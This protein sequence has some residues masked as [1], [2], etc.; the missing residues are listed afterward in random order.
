MKH[1]A[2]IF[3]FCGV[4]FAGTCAAE[5]NDGL[6]GSSIGSS[7]KPKAPAV[8]NPHPMNAPQMA[9]QSEA[10]GEVMEVIQVSG[11]TYLRLHNQGKDFWIAGTQTQAKKGDTARFVENVTMQ[12]FTSKTLNR[13]FDSIIFASS[14]VIEAK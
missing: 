13:T 8:A 14:V 7:S 10:Q 4:I 9:P 6:G 5:I 2:Q 3:M 12:N 1:R 11:F